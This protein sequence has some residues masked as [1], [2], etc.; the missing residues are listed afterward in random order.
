MRASKPGIDIYEAPTECEGVDRG[1]RH[2]PDPIAE[3][4]R[5]CDGDNALGDL[6]EV[7]LEKWIVPDPGLCL[8]LV[9][10][11][12]RHAFL[13]GVSEAR[14]SNNC[15]QSC[16]AS[17]DTLRE[18]RPSSTAGNEDRKTDV[19]NDSEPRIVMLR[20][21]FHAPNPPNPPRSLI[22]LPSG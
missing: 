17:L 14:P 6:G 3:R 5:L 10:I 8:E 19:G 7:R 13:V 18:R 9:G 22:A 21:H 20:F 2:D 4:S 12:L 1:I 11:G 15:L 16:H